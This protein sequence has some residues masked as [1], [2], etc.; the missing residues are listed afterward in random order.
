M[1]LPI[2]QDSARFCEMNTR[3]VVSSSGYA[4][5]LSDGNQWHLNADA[6]LLPW[7]EKFAGIMGLN[8]GSFNGSLKLTYYLNSSP[9]LSSPHSE[10]QHVHTHNVWECTDLRSL[11]VCFHK[12]S[13]EVKCK[14][15]LLDE[16]KL[17]NGKSTLEFVS[18]WNAL[19]PIYQQ[20]IRQGGLPIHAA[21]VE[22]NGAG[23]LLAAPG[24]TGKSTCCRRLP[25]DWKPLCD[26]ETL[27]VLDK[28]K[29]F[30]GHPFPT[31]SDY[32][33]RGSNRTWDVQYSV[34]LGGIFFLEQSET[35]ETMNLGQGE[36]A[37]FVY[38]SVNQACEKY[39]RRGNTAFQRIFRQELFNNA[40]GFA[41]RI[42]AFRLRVSL[43][44]RFW[45]KI[46]QALG[47]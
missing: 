3:P 45:E 35:E 30:R 12:Y 38:E 26:D 13:S 4:L 37:A 21:L 25:D 16:S 29:R 27:V 31:W 23:V 1:I 6:P 42:P 28:G 5:S 41:K 36:A 17:E 40:C 43:N 2:S 44:G 34:P 9:I 19:F 47:W 24:D 32:V 46:E 20:S 10:I 7:L 15:K 11:G 33:M 8:Q 22:K 39:W 14:I 18:M